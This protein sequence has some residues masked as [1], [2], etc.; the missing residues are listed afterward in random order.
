MRAGGAKRLRAAV[1]RTWRIGDKTGSGAYGTTNDIAI[2][3][4]PGR[5]P[6]LTAVFY[7]GSQ[8]AFDERERVIAAIGQ[9]IVSSI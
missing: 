8:A 5:A 7:T 4:P 1:P 2:I 6:I 3:R 9:I